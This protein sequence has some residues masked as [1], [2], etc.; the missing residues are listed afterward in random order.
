MS[1]KQNPTRHKQRWVKRKHT[2]SSENEHFEEEE[3]EDAQ[4]ELER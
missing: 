2:V 1:K 4:E 3:E